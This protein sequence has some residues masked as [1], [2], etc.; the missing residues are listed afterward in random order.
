MNT[1][2]N[3][4]FLKE[5]FTY[6]GPELR[7]LFLYEKGLKG[8]GVMAWIGPCDVKTNDLVDAEDRVQNDFI[9]S[10]EMVHFLCEF[11]HKDVFFGICVQR[12]MAE[13]VIDVLTENKITDLERQGDDVYLLEK[14]KKK[15]LNVSIATVSPLSTLVHFGVNVDS[16]GA[17]VA[18][19]GLKDLGVDSQKFTEALLKR[20]KKEV[21]QIYEASVKV[22][23]V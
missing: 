6:T 20:V 1:I 16:E 2:V 3:T 17:P 10:K 19:V 21:E 12:L 23:S 18:A 11:F 5:E 7:S 22:M 14:E 9:K 8:D 15:K 13:I 4:L